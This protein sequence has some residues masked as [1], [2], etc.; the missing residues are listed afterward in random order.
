MSKK[1]FE[2][3]KRLIEKPYKEKSDLLK[4]KLLAKQDLK[5][6]IK[7]LRLFSL[8]RGLTENDIINTLEEVVRDY[9]WEEFTK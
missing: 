5:D 7:Q 6:G 1:T 8:N 4:A 2:E 9:F 3:I